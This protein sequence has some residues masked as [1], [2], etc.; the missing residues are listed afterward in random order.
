M[1]AD[2]RYAACKTRKEL[3]KVYKRDK[4]GTYSK[5]YIKACDVAYSKHYARLYKLEM[6][7]NF[8][9]RTENHNI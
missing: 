1:T 2:E 8:H 7:A 9:I 5:E 3:N 4:T 6:E